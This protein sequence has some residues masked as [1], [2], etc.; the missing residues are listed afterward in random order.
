[1]SLKN[2]IP[3]TK[4]ITVAGLAEAARAATAEGHEVRDA[5]VVVVLRRRQDPAI[6]RQA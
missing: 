1:M 3:Y 2:L 5:S 4:D 6:S